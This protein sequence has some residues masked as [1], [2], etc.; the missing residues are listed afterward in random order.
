[1][2][3]KELE[4]L[5]IE[6]HAVCGKINGHGYEIK[7]VLGQSAA[8]AS[9]LDALLKHPDQINNEGV[10]RVCRGQIADVQRSLKG[11]RTIEASALGDGGREAG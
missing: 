4:A 7:A 8:I 11:T 6:L 9:T 1:M 10:R 5:L 2:N 3:I